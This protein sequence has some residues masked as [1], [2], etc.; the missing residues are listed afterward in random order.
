M[1]KKDSQEGKMEIEE[2]KGV[3]ETTFFAL[4]LQ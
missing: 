4:R 3:S 2:K 1:D